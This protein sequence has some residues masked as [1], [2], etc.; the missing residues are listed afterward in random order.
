MST[1]QRYSLFLTI[2]KIELIYCQSQ[3]IF[4]IIKESRRKEKC[5]YTVI[6]GI[7]GCPTCKRAKEIAERLKNERDDFDFKYV[8]V[9]KENLSKRDIEKSA[10]KKIES[11]PQI[12]ID[13]HYLGDFNAFE[14]FAKKELGLYST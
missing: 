13:E 12:F 2:R 3:I 5:M 14:Q 10:G 6:F 11:I 7:A 4:G 8:D 1:N 9:Q